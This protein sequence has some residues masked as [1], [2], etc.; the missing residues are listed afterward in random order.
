MQFHLLG[1]RP[2][3]SDSIIDFN[4]PDPVRVKLDQF[5]EEIETKAWHRLA[6]LSWMPFEEARDFARSNTAK[7]EDKGPGAPKGERWTCT[8]DAFDNAMKHFN[9]E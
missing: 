5:V 8:H 3:K 1:K 2:K 7:F 6:K 4:V 9:G